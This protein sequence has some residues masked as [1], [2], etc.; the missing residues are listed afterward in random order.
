MRRF[1]LLLNYISVHDHWWELKLLKFY[2]VQVFL[3]LLSHISKFKTITV[4]FLVANSL[5]QVSLKRLRL[6]ITSFTILAGQY[7]VTWPVQTN[8]ASGN[9]N[10]WW[11]ITGDITNDQYVYFSFTTTVLLSLP[12][13][14]SMFGTVE[15]LF[16]NAQVQVSLNHFQVALVSYHSFTLCGRY[17]WMLD[18][19]W[20]LS[21]ISDI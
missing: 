11:I 5:I 21:V 10:V 4:E 16:T 9:E 7:L 1:V 3:L 14:I 17:Q 12:S 19:D 8:R 15:S 6:L 18:N 20:K 13:D 2:Q